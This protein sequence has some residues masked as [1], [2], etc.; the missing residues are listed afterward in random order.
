MW[1]AVQLSRESRRTEGVQTLLFPCKDHEMAG[2]QFPSVE[3]SY[4][5][6]TGREVEDD[7]GIEGEDDVVVVE[8]EADVEGN[9]DNT[10]SRRSK[11][12]RCLGWL[13][14]SPVRASFRWTS[15]SSSRWAARV[16]VSAWPHSTSGSWARCCARRGRWVRAGAVVRAAARN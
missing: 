12:L 14:W 16:D 7:V 11:F 4:L 10:S 6:G 9:D 8:G 1:G 3:R 5:T 15:N 13:R 2:Y